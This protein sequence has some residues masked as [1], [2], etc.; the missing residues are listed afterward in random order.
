MKKIIY[1]GICLLTPYFVAS[2]TIKIEYN[3]AEK[4]FKI[5][6]CK[7]EGSECKE[8]NGDIKI[9][10]SYKVILSGINTAVTKTVL[11]IKPFDLESATPAIIQPIF[12]GI[13][14]SGQI[15][16]GDGVA[17]S[18]DDPF[19]DIYNLSNDALAHYNELLKVK[20]K[21]NDLYKITKF[22]TNNTQAIVEFEALCT[23]FYVTSGTNKEKIVELNQ[24]IVL[25]QNYINT[26]KDIFIKRLEFT[27][28]VPSDVVERYS[29]VLIMANAVTKTNFTKYSKF[30]YQS[31]SSKNQTNLESFIAKSDGTDLNL[32]LL[33]TYVNDTITKKTF[34]FYTKGNWSFDFSTGFFYSNKVE[35]SYYLETRESDTSKKII[36][37]E[38]IRDFDISFGALGHLSYKF[39]SRFKAGISMGAS[40]SPIDGK[41]R[42]LLGTSFIFGRKNQLALNGG[43]S[44]V[45]LKVLSESVSYDA[46]GSYVDSSVTT[47]PTY[48]K[49][50][51]GFF[52][53]VTYNLTSKK[54]Y[55]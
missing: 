4:N 36:L 25:Y 11:K 3:S 54:K 50:Q 41:T 39:T 8:F 14:S 2:Q 33:N 13:T 17:K 19:L 23:A 7:D 29:N 12:S 34:D 46:L 35:Q 55:Q 30:I 10:E 21:S 24:K 20:K 48:E 47:V 49:V 18:K 15:N 22:S 44:L 53:G 26:V 45:K 51:S 38:P 40:L 16:L 31:I 28:N 52:I 9:G 1:L 43:L 27:R 32:T 5:L 37:E 42:Y 6:E